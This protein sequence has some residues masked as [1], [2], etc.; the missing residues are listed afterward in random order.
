YVV[1][2]RIGDDAEEEK[3]GRAKKKGPEEDPDKRPPLAVLEIADELRRGALAGLV[4]E[5]LHGRMHP[6]EK[7]DVMR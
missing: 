7:D 2:P 6:D 1:C 4:V 5:V 3:K